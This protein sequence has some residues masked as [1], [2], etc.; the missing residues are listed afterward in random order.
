MDK[1]EKIMNWA[2]KTIEN[3][4]GLFGFADWKI[5]VK[6][7]PSDDE[8]Y[9]Y[10]TNIKYLDKEMVIALTTLFF[11]LDKEQQLNILIH[12]LIHSRLLVA[13]LKTEKMT[14]DIKYYNEEEAVNDIT[15]GVMY[16]LE[17]SKR[18]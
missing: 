13:Q 11:D 4:K 2:D 8:D 15:N 16:F 1:I 7:D 5:A 9:A 17:R 10:S 14:E 12:E 18:K 6:I 3:M